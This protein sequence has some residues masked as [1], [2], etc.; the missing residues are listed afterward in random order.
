MTARKT[1]TAISVYVIVG[2]LCL[3]W[4][5][6]HRD[7]T[8]AKCLDAAVFEEYKPWCTGEGPRDHLARAQVRAVFWPVWL[9]FELSVWAM[10]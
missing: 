8:Y 9:A 1:W 3:G 2:F 10:R 7:E 4:N 5:L 6:N